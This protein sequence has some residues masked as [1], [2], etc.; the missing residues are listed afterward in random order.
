MLAA[1]SVKQSRTAR[2]EHLDV[3]RSYSCV[4]QIDNTAFSNG[5]LLRLDT[6]AAANF[7]YAY[8]VGDK[9]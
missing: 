4:G 5:K 6:P 8:N 3:L 7:L 9:Y 1:F 2:R